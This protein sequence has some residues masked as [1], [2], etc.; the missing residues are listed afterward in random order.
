MFWNAHIKECRF[1]PDDTREILSSIKLENLPWRAKSAARR[2]GF[3]PA[4][5]RA[6][7]QLRRIVAVF[8]TTCLVPLYV[9]TRAFISDSSYI[10]RRSLGRRHEILGILAGAATI[11]LGLALWSY[12][13]R[14]GEN[15]VGPVGEAIA[16]FFV[17]AFG[18]G[19]AW[20]PIELG[21]LTFELFRTQRADA[22]VT[23]V[24]SLIVVLL[25]RLRADAPDAA[26]LSVVFGGHIRPAV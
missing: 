16:G 5:G 18:L 10:G 26:R 8:A 17:S 2:H 13:Q 1:G 6:P 7:D 20:L 3:A 12:D 21:L 9:G 25:H 14:G 23:R 4:I 24:A 11:L 15:W 19:A 22:W